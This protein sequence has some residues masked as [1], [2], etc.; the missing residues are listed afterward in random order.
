VVTHIGNVAGE[1]AYGE[2]R[3]ATYMANTY[4]FYRREHGAISSAL[5]R[6]MN[7]AG[8]ALGYAR[9][10]RTHDEDLEHFWRIQLKAHL[11]RARDVEQKPARG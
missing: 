7:V 2:R 3:T 4:R 9:A 10:R 6:G 8:A 5:Y 11:A 1:A